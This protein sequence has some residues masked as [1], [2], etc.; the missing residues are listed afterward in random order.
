MK[1]RDAFKPW[2]DRTKPSSKPKKDM[3]G[4]DEPSLE[5]F[6]SPLRR[7]LKA[8]Y[9]KKRKLCN[10]H[11]AGCKFKSGSG[12]A[13]DREAMEAVDSL[14]DPQPYLD[15][16]R[17]EL[18]ESREINIKLINRLDRAEKDLAPISWIRRGIYYTVTATSLTIAWQIAKIVLGI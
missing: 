5:E 9:T 16:V 15:D 11:C 12:C 1:L 18:V 14:E 3:K 2:K 8:V 7:T 10:Y 17:R 4:P 13:L 6:V